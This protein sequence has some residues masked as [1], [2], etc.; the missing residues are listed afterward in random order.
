MSKFSIVD[1][2]NYHLIAVHRIKRL[3]SEF[4]FMAEFWFIFFFFICFAD[5]LFCNFVVV[6][7][8]VNE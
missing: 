4:V 5:L 7:V 1:Y 2:C 8:L 3:F 6:V